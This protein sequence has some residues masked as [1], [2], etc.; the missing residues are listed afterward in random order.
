MDL[1]EGRQKEKR[2]GKKKKRFLIFL[3]TYL[4]YLGP[5]LSHIF[6]TFPNLF[7][8]RAYGDAYYL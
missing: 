5:M 4:K 6:F 2:E 3:A 7:C 8:H 1:M